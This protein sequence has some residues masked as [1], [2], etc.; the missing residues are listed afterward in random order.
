MKEGKEGDDVD[1]IDEGEEG[2]KGN[3]VFLKKKSSL[4]YFR[5]VV[6]VKKNCRRR[7]EAGGEDKARAGDCT[8]H[9]L[10]KLDHMCPDHLFKLLSI[11]PK[12]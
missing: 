5:R 6:Q 10:I 12:I 7:G 1:K 8:L 3:H 9:Q 4:P 2:D 11:C